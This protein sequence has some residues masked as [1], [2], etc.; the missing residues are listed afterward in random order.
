MDESGRV[1]ANE[2]GEGH[3]ELQLGAYQRPGIE[4]SDAVL[5]LCGFAGLCAVL[6]N[7]KRP[8]PHGE[9]RNF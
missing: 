8:L 7:E 9:A 4:Q 2:R 6:R 1:V 5:T 3:T